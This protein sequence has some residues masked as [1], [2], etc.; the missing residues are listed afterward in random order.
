M[1]RCMPGS[2]SLHSEAEPEVAL[3]AYTEACFARTARAPGTGG[4]STN[5]LRRRIVVVVT[6]S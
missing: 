4:E 6:N 5:L 2:V 1:G 3:R